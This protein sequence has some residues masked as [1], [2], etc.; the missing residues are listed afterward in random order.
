MDTDEDQ[1]ESEEQEG[2]MENQLKRDKIEA[3]TTPR[4]EVWGSDRSGG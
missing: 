2:Q 4:V 3:H 1:L